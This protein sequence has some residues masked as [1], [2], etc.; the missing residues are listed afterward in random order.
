MKNIFILTKLEI[1]KLFAKG[2]SYIAFGAIAFLVFVIQIALVVDGENFFEFQTQNLRD[3]F[4]FEGNLLNGYLTVYVILTALLIHIPFL[5]ALVSGDL[6]AGE[7]SAGT[8]RFLLTRSASRLEIITAKFITCIFYSTLLVIAMA[9]LSLVSGILLFGKGDLF[10]VRDTIYIFS[11][12]DVLWRLIASFGF[13][14]LGMSTVASLAFLFSSFTD[15]SV[16]PI[17][18]T[19][20]IIIAFMILSS[21]DLSIFKMIKPFFFTTYMNNW[22][23]LF[24]EPFNLS[25]LVNSSLI[26]VFHIVLFFGISAWN[27]TKKDIL[28]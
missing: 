4:L 13:S 27:F 3:T 15:N 7:T 24:E 10:V 9:V 23:L 20:V 26:L 17:I 12:N 11:E 18:L 19:M 16:T 25:K 14:I 2:R 28:S 5:I 22:R 8:L 6:I 21:I 1:F